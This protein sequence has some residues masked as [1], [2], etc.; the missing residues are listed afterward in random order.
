MPK[1]RVAVRIGV[2]ILAGFWAWWSWP[3]V[4]MAWR[5]YGRD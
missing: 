4:R 2:L 1:A 5:W 3:L